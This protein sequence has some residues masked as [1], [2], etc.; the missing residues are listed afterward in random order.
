MAEIVEKKFGSIKRFGARYG[1]RIREKVSK[2]E[3]KQ[4]LPN[5]CPYCKRPSARR[6]ATGLWQC[7]K[8]RAKFA[9]GAYFLEEKIV[10]A[11]GEEK[12]KEI[13]LKSKKAEEV[14]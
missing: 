10:R 3:Q 9:G 13:V 11:T 7:N 6:L 4:K 8:C 14:A 2:I 12:E 5:K 1:R